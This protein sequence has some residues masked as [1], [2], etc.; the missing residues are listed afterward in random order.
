L[1][2]TSISILVGAIFV[3]MIWFLP[4][5]SW[6]QIHDLSSHDIRIVLI[7]LGFSSLLALQEGLFHGSF[8]CVGKYALG[9]VAKSVIQLGTFAGL[10][11]A[12]LL[13]ANLVQT[14]VV[15]ALINA[16]GTLVLWRLLRRQIEWVRY[17]TQY[18]HLS[19]LRRLFWPAVSFM[20]FPISNI[21]T[22]QGILIVV[23]HMFGP[24]GVVTFSTARTISRSVLQALQLINASVLP[25]VS[26]AFGAGSLALV[27]RLH[28]TSCQ[29]SIL[30]CAGTTMLVAVFGNA[31]W[32]IWILGKIQTDPVLLYFLLL[33]MFIGSL[34][35]TS[36][37]VPAATNNHRQVAKVV[38]GASVMSLV[39]SYPLMKIDILGLR[40]AAIALVLG[41][42]LIAL[43]VFK[44]SLRLVE[45]TVPNFFRSL[46][47]VPALPF[48]P[49]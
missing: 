35:F 23:G 34:W 43:F 29:V 8:R 40:G 39:L 36:L 28:R 1:L 41:D 31:V 5:E 38:L 3:A 27:R 33:Q 4:L 37:V 49:K 7:I 6:L 13:G 11:T 24:V 15:I 44:T 30:V 9:T 14:S 45:D 18:A 21:L 19:T 2:I 48:R 46:L 10:V 17:G 12:V 16:V 47:E 25:E 42:I 20:S 26:A 32:K 22:L